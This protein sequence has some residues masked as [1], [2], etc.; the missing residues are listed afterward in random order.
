MMAGRVPFQGDNTLTVLHMQ[1]H[2]PP[3][4]IVGILPEVQAILERAL[5][6]NPDDRYQSTRE[7]AIDYSRAAGITPS[8]GVNRETYPATTPPLDVAGPTALEPIIVS[9]PVRKTEQIVEREPEKQPEPPME[10]QR[11]P[12]PAPKPA[13]S[14]SWIGIGLFSLVCLGLLAFGAFRLLSAGRGLVSANP[15]ET[16]ETVSPALATDTA[17]SPPASEAPALPPATNMV[18]IPAGAY[19]VGKDPA[20]A[21][22][23]APQTVD[24]T[25][26]WIDQYETTNAEYQEFI[27][28]TAAST[29]AA[30][31]PPAGQERFP[32]RGVGWDQAN[33]YCQWRT[34]RLPAEAEWEAAGRGN[35]EDPPRLY[36]WGDLTFELSQ[37]LNDLY[38]VGTLSFNVSPLG[39]HDLVGN[40]WEWVGEPYVPV[41]A[42]GYRVLHGGRY[43]FPQELAYRVEVSPDDP[44]Y[45]QYFENAGFRCAADQV[46]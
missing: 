37:Q 28:A 8:L 21:N 18:Q 17:T 12:E 45:P 22:Y 9:E 34:K 20:N 36:P 46:R 33:A 19:Q 42:D 2:T 14:R 39:V 15:T 35:E 5:K 43:G 13:R 40:V 32:V 44:A 10:P 16:V 23:V 3:P 31:P 4:P 24:L 7:L 1:I 27:D 26:F 30:W 38:E 41:Q 11:P 25:S 6:K 29:P